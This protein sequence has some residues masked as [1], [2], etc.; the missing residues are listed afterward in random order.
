MRHPLVSASL[1]ALLLAVAAVPATAAPR[2]DV[3]QATSRLAGASSY[4]IHVDSPQAGMAGSMELQYVAPDR[5]RMM[6]PGGPVQTIIGNQAYMEIAGRTMRV[7]L[8]AG[9]L[10]KMRDQARIS[11]TQDNA[12]IESLGSDMLDGKPTTKYRIVHAGQREAEALLWVDGKGWPLQMQVDGDDGA[13]TTMR[14]SRFNDPTLVI[15]A[16]D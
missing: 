11:E 6:I 12:R 2:D 10:D 15:A 8:P 1:A 5:Y 16:P 3:I 4:V 7:P 9:S 14:Y 13:T